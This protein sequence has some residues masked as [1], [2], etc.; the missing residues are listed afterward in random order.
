[1][2]TLSTPLF[3]AIAFVLVAFVVVGWMFHQGYFLEEFEIESYEREDGSTVTRSREGIEIEPPPD[4]FAA[5]GFE[6]IEAYIERLLSSE[7][8]HT[9]I[10]FAEPSGDKGFLIWKHGDVVEAVMGADRF[11]EP[12]KEGRIRAYFR[13]LSIG[14]T[15]DY[16]S[17]NGPVK[18]STRNL[19][20]PLSEQTVEALTARVEDIMQTIEDMSPDAAMEVRYDEK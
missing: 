6:H 19:T 17:Q 15:Q 8:E 20:Y 18:D 10:I 7:A 11:D 14:P 9:S 2:F 13:E 4:K 5:D 16:L 12:E 1:M 3:I